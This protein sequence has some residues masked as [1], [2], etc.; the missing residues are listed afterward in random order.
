MSKIDFRP[1]KAGKWPRARPRRGREL[2]PDGFP[3]TPPDPQG[4]PGSDPGA[5]RLFYFSPIKARLLLGNSFFV[6]CNFRV[7]CVHFLFCQ[8]TV[9]KYKGQSGVSTYIRG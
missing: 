3:T 1:P 5:A 9:R 2:R 4:T 6:L 8:N 7:S